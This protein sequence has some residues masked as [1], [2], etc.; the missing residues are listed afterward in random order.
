MKIKSTPNK[1]NTLVHTG[2]LQPP[3]WE[4]VEGQKHK[5]VVQTEDPIVFILAG[6]SERQLDYLS[7]L[8]ESITARFLTHVSQSIFQF[9]SP[10]VDT[11][12]QARKSNEPKHI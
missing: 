12:M 5:H 10:G 3:L 11:W 1:N 4:K 8:E 6:L 2:G 9:L 7:C